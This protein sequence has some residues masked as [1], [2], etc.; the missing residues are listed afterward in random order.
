MTDPSP[1]GAVIPIGQ[2]LLLAGALCV[3][4][5]WIDQA[6]QSTKRRLKYHLMKLQELSNELI[7]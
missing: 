6:V 2:L 5:W 7:G 3:C 4:C 1:E